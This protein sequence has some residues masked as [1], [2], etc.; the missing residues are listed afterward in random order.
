MR[1]VRRREKLCVAGTAAAV[2]P[3]ASSSPEFVL[4]WD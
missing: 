2:A 3:V 4:N 1:L